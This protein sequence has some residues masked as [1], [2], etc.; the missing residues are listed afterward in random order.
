MVNDT[1]EA[2]YAL[3][4]AG[5]QIR[6]TRGPLHEM[7]EHV[8]GASRSLFE[9]EHRVR[10]GATDG[11]AADMM[12]VARHC[13]VAADEGVQ[14][15][16]RLRHAGQHIESAQQHASQI[17]TSGLGAPE[18]ADIADLRAR[19]EAYGQAVDLAR[20]MATAAS[21][22]L[23]S[24]A[25]VAGRAA[26]VDPAGGGR[27]IDQDVA[28]IETVARDLGRAQEGGRHLGRTVAHAADAGEKSLTNPQM[29]RSIAEEDQW[30][31]N[32]NLQEAATDWF[33]R[34]EAEQI[35][36]EQDDDRP[37]REMEMHSREVAEGN[38]NVRV[39]PEEAG[40]RAAD[41]RARLSE[42]SRRPPAPTGDPAG[43]RASGPRR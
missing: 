15:A 18:A 39:S 12:V 35:S 2:R 41:A 38:Y 29:T 25:D 43:P 3:E 10:A 14:I 26:R 4:E 34:S 19:I 37:M 24:A 8:A 11:T 30:H 16:T 5:A 6:W 9:A 7:Q 31:F 27:G 21:E 36:A 13:Q 42:Q 20:P 32:E 28:S 22:H 23:Y 1:Y 17:D 40:Q 33:S